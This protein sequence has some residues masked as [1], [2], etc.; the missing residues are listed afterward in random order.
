MVYAT[1]AV[2]VIVAFM[3]HTHDSGMDIN[4]LDTEI[5]R[6]LFVAGEMTDLVTAY[7]MRSR[8]IRLNRVA[9]AV[10]WDG[11]L[12]LGHQPAP[13]NPFVVLPMSRHASRLRRAT[14]I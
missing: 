5:L 6:C 3:S 2:N 11:P 9:E 4:D 7:D 13:P 1:L 12:V 14:I 8:A 10:E